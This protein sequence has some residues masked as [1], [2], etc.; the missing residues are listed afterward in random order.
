MNKNIT[1]KPIKWEYKH[2]IPPVA[3]LQL[4]DLPVNCEFLLRHLLARAH[5]PRTARSQRVRGVVQSLGPDAVPLSAAACFLYL[6]FDPRGGPHTRAPAARHTSRVTVS[7]R[8]INSQ[9]RHRAKM[10]R[11]G[12]QAE[13]GEVRD[14]Q[15]ERKKMEMR[16]KPFG[17]GDF[18]FFLLMR[19]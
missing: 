6:V 17:F 5:S 15:Q 3:T 8:C 7:H 19:K 1:N 13:R 4:R 9:R 10:R 18:F 16:L 14:L 12:A 2:Q 11:G